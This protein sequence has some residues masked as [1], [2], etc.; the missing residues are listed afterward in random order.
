MI[1]AQAGLPAPPQVAG[2]TS[3]ILLW[4]VIVLGLAVLGLATLLRHYAGLYRDEL[5]ENTRREVAA[6]SDL[7]TARATLTASQARIAELEAR[8]KEAPRG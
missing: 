3:Q 2:E 4:I 7:A 1:L 6:A 8:L 5:I